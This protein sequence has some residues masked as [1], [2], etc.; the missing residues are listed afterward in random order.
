[1][2]PDVRVVV[3]DMTEVSMLDMSAIVVL[4]SIADNLSMR[5]VGLVINDLKPR[6][7]LKL[8]RAGIR[9]KLGKVEF[10]RNLDE[11]LRKALAM[12]KRS[13]SG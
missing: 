5:G 10:S 9:K 2:A 4:E 6:M 13:L 1:M 11:G 8:R 3:L 7:I 12:G